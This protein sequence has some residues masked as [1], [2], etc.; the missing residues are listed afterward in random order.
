MNEK[1]RQVK[2]E[3]LKKGREK[4]SQ[5]AIERYY[6]DPAICEQCGKIIELDGK[7]KPADIKQKKFCDRS[8]AAKF[9]NLGKDRWADKRVKPKR[10]EHT[11]RTVHTSDGSPIPFVCQ[12]CNSTESIIPRPRKGRVGQYWYYSK[13][14]CNKCARVV[15][16]SNK[17]CTRQKLLSRGE[18]TGIGILKDTL[19]T[20]IDKGITKGELRTASKTFQYYQIY[21]NRHARK[22]YNES[23]KPAHCKVCGYSLHTEV[24]HI[25]GL[26]SFHDDVPV[27][28]INDIS[29]LERLCRNH[30]WEFDNGHISLD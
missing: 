23:E 1:L 19:Y 22:V 10:P 11:Q 8:C 29:N 12:M 4:Q 26:K 20:L 14:Y 21:V 28:E 13:K 3:N 15:A 5:E 24:C 17:E 27:K 2:L 16:T 9:N 18:T 6:R 7:Q 30:H 25:K